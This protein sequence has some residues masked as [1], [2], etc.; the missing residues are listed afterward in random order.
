V[1]AQLTCLWCGEK[2]EATMPLCR[3]CNPHAE[4]AAMIT[5][6]HQ[7]T[8]RLAEMDPFDQDGNCRV[9]EGLIRHVLHDEGYFYATSDP[10]THDP[11]CVWVLATRAIERADG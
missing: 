8:R 1:T 3:R 2:R 4:F 9:C 5:A 6:H 7:V 10:G 11:E